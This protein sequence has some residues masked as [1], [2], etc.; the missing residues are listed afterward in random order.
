MKFL[1]STISYKGKPV[2]PVA[3]LLWFALAIAAVVAE[4]LH[5]SINNY[6]IYTGVFRHV[7][8]QRNLYLQYPAEYYDSNHYGPLFSFI[9]AP[10]AV[11]PDL[12]GVTLWVLANA[13]FLYYAIRQLPLNNN[14]ILAVYL[15]SVIEFMTS[16]HNVQFNAMLA[17]WI[18][19]S[20]VLVSRQK[21]FWATLFIAAG[22]L[23]KLY[24]IVGILFFVFSEH[25]MKFI[26]SILFW[27]VVLFCLPMLISSPVFIMQSYHDWINALTGKNLANISLDSNNM[28]DISVMGMIRRITKYQNLSNLL[29]IVPAAIMLALPLLRYKLY[30]N[31][32]F[33]LYY[34]CLVLISAVIYS[35][36]AESATYV[37]A[38]VAVAIWYVINMHKQSIAIN[39]VLVMA[40]LLTSLSATDLCPYYIKHY[41]ILAYSLKALPCFIVWLILICNVAFANEETFKT[42]VLNE[43]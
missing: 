37:L 12:P 18:I 27:L 30:R 13:Y 20:Y 25:K 5:H 42:P 40:L 2:L 35:S 24:G 41:I 10:F 8:E 1:Y 31:T 36:S 17:A 7:I 22:F 34:L 11:L 3:V 23:I 16:C 14:A 9:I 21:D 26:V 29:V 19:L 38:M 4:L 28:Q 32:I 15:I 39:I 43:A 6:Q 33:Q